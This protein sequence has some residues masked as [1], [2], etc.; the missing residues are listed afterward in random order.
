MPELPELKVVRRGLERW[1]SG[2]TVDSVLVYPPRAVR[3]H[4]AGPDDF[5]AQ[6]AGPV[7]GPAQRP[8]K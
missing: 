4:T 1:V 3:R 5:P 6:L 2:R 8:G 7:L